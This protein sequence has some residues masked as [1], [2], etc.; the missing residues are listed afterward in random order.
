MALMLMYVSYRYLGQSVGGLFSPEYRDAPWSW[1]KL[2]DLLHASV[3]PDHRHR[4]PTGTAA[5]IRIMRANLS[6]EL[7][8][9]YVVTARAKGLPEFT[10]ILQ[11][12]GAY[13]AEPVHL[14]DRLGAAGSS[15]PA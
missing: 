3:D 13:R 5:L 11:L 8:K 9:P 2:G 1:A 6:D 12:S 10:L 7:N 4:P 14:D 15:S